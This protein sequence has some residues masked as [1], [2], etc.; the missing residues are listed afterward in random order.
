MVDESAGVLEPKRSEVRIKRRV[1]GL[2]PAA[3]GEG[4]RNEKSQLSAGMRPADIV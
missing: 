1:P 2:L 4:A 3:E